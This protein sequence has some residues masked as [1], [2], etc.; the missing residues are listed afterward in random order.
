MYFFSLLGVIFSL[1]VL[2]YGSPFSI[3]ERTM[4]HQKTRLKK[5][6]FNQKKIFFFKYDHDEIVSLYFT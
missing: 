3:S 1:S 2:F 6:T 5:I 4:R